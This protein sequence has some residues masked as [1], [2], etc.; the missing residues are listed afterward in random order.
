MSAGRQKPVRLLITGGGTG[1]HL[2]P[3]VAAA[4]ALRLRQPQC[5]VLFIGTRRKID[6]TTLAG[7][8]FASAA[9]HSY[10]LKG[11]NYWTWSKL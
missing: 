2:F 6:T 10:G 4:Q 3:A 8:G 9:I 11:K 7:Y 1:G 5:E